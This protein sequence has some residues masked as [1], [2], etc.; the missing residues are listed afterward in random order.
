MLW[1][2]RST[3]FLGGQGLFFNRFANEFLRPAAS[4]N[5]AESRLEVYQPG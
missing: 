3:L 5:P 4:Q 2:N 1:L